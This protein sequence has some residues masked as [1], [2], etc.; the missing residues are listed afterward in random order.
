MSCGN[1]EK[2]RFPVSGSGGDNSEHDDLT[3]FENNTNYEL[4][5]RYEQ[6]TGNISMATLY[7]HEFAYEC[8]PS[9]QVHLPA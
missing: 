5:R 1:G 9:L 3:G 6:E 2:S 8:D 7:F 4:F